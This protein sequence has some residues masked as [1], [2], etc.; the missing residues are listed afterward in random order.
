MKKRLIAI[1]L[2]LC[3]VLSLSACAKNY[4]LEK[5]FVENPVEYNTVNKSTE[6]T[7][8]KGATHQNSWGCLAVFTKESKKIIFDM[9]KNAVVHTIND[10]KTNV[11]GFT[12]N[13]SAFILV[14]KD[15]ETKLYD[16]N[17]N[18]IASAD[19]QITSATH[20]LD[21]FV[22]DGSVYRVANDTVTKVGNAAFLPDISSFS[23]HVA[24]YYYVTSYSKVFVYNESLKLVSSW[25]KESTVYTTSAFILSNGNVLIQQTRVLPLDAKKFTYSDSMAKYELT[26]YIMNPKNGKLT[27]KNLDYVVEELVDR[28]NTEDSLFNA[29]IKN[30]AIIF[31]IENQVLQNGTNTVR[32][33]SLKNNGKIDGYIFEDLEGFGHDDFEWI[34]ND[35]FAYETTSGEIYITD[36][37]GNFLASISD[38]DGCNKVGVV[39]DGVIYDWSFGNAF[40]L[41]EE[42]MTLVAALN[43]CFILKDED[44]YYR[45]ANGH[46]TSIGEEVYYNSVADYYIVDGEDNCT[47]YNSNGTKIGTFASYPYYVTSYDG[48]YI[49]R[50]Y[51][52]DNGE[53]R[54]YMLSE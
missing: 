9:E 18:L 51:D 49:V 20:N 35:R 16:K 40:D 14:C 28:N 44:A 37:S 30:I 33:V 1:A 54:F 31:P 32:M 21:M 46:K 39:I 5:A 43:D 42:E 7:A 38:I 4:S 2:L 17:Y 26:S 47:M 12:V 53:Y 6:I 27:E 22:F 11:Y 15:K 45:Y 34:T 3:T 13:D 25:E 8:L 50:V 41:E 23:Y 48:N 29:K 10:E 19:R 36:K 52:V 24:G